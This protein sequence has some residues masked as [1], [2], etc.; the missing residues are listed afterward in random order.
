MR[1]DQGSPGARRPH[2][3]M[4]ALYDRL[5]IKSWVYPKPI[6]W[7]SGIAVTDDGRS[8]YCGA[9]AVHAHACIRRMPIRLW[10]KVQEQTKQMRL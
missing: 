7:K 10:L 5:T 6:R 8:Q 2:P 3:A 4:G 1:V 9:E